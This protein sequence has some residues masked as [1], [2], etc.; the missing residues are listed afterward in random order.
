MYLHIDL[1][2]LNHKIMSKK[3]KSKTPKKDMSIGI[4]DPT[5]QNNNPLTDKEYS[6][7]Y[8]SLSK[9]W[10]KFPAYEDAENIINQIKTHNVILVVSGT[11]SGKTVLFPKYVLHSFDY[12]AKIAITLPKQLITKSAAQFAADTLDVVL[13]DEVGYQYR[14]AGKE[15]FSEK[16]KL[17]YCT[18]GTLVAR[19]LSDPELN[20]FDA[21]VVDEAHERKVNIDFLLY[22]LRNVLNNRPKFKLVIMSAT[23]NESIFRDYFKDYNYVN[24]SIGTKTNYPIESIFL[25]KPLNIDKNEYLD[26]GI[27]LLQSLLKK[28]DNGGILFFVTSVNETNDVCDVLN[29]DSQFK[30]INIC[31]PV[32]SGM[33][34][35]QQKIAT[36]KEYYRQFVKDGRKIIVATNVAESSLT[37]EGIQYV[38][39]SGLELKSRY[40]PVERVNILEKILITHAQAKQRMGR[41]GRTGPGVC[42]HLYTKEMFDEKMDRFPSPAIRIESINYEMIR[43][44][45]IPSIGTIG[46]LKEVLQ[47]FIEP[48]NETY[49]DFELNYLMKLNLIDSI[50]DSGTLTGLGKIVSNLQLEPFQVLSMLMGFRLN[51]FREVVSILAVIDACKG[52]MDQLFVLPLDILDDDTSQNKDKVKWLTDKFNKAKEHFANKYGDHIAILKMFGEYEKKRKDQDKLKEWSYK[53]F[54]KRDILEKAYQ[55][56]QK[57]KY[58]YRNK[59]DS[60]HM[61]KP[62]PNM[63][64]QD[65]KYRVMASLIYGY[66]LNLLKVSKEKIIIQDKEAKNSKTVQIDKSSFVTDPTS[67]GTEMF[68][69]RLH[70]YNKNPIKA[71][72]V[73]KIS[74]KSKDILNSIPETL[75]TSDL[76]IET[77]TDTETDVEI[78]PESDDQ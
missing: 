31:V 4:L 62:D 3:S 23:I 50:Q 57:M 33:S 65:I 15:T 41:T 43:L 7:S 75:L 74:K 53:Y 1:D 76:K 26:Y 39:D 78:D 8:K 12:N 58:R 60:L 2:T 16:T 22:L 42:Y 55:T 48:P 63:L 47:N 28:P 20:D 51:C 46:D 10:S 9:V 77:D 59:I 29:K 30:E 19:L 49:V 73:T 67:K 44:L 61:T 24:L 21:V 18:D 32:Y 56:Y 71:Q 70:R 27:K 68:F 66:K 54:I 52:S 64:H 37:I 5:G 38:I 11:G 45:A 34:E 40:D 36:D 72:I 69:H 25:D 6:E 35:D 13:G 17:L 14:N